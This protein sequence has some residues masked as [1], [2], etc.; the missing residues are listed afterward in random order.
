MPG[1]K[2]C[3]IVVPTVNVAAA[4]MPINEANHLYRARHIASLAFRIASMLKSAG[5]LP[6][7]ANRV[8]NAQI[9]C[10]GLDC[11]FELAIERPTW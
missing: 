10:H 5:I 1:Q 3:S 8:D 2:V 9:H 4:R 7:A 6:R 11:C